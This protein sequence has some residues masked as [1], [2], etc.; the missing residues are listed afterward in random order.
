DSGLILRVKNGV[1]VVSSIAYHDVGPAEGPTPAPEPTATPTPSST[2]TATATETSAAAAP[3]D[4]AEAS[5]TGTPEAPTVTETP[6][7]VTPTG[8]PTSE[9]PTE[10]PTPEAPTEVPTETP[11]PEMPT[12]TPTEVP[13][14]PTATETPVVVTVTSVPPCEVDSFAIE[15]QTGVAPFTGKQ[16]RLIWRVRNAASIAIRWKDDG[17]DRAYRSTNLAD[18]T[19][20]GVDRRDPGDLTFQL[21]AY[22]DQAGTEP[23][24]VGPMA[25]VLSI[26][27]GAPPTTPIPQ[28]VINDLSI[29]P[30]TGV[31]PFNGN[32]TVRWNASGVA[33]I[34]IRWADDKGGRFVSTSSTG[35]T[36]IGVSKRAAGPIPFEITGYRDPTASGQSCV[37][38]STDLTVTAP[39]PPTATTRP[40][41]ILTPIIIPPK[42]PP[43]R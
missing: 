8:T 6:I 37:S 40:I 39:Q 27:P 1:V 41:I 33:S 31:A 18:E 21:F 5:P 24:C 35:S 22:R 15:P 4:A 14:Q 20:Q 36:Q 2:P 12:E 23:A 19:A 42:L 9:P 13:A 29:S 25:K 17:G 34:A 32:V 10:T 26:A 30:T 16:V 38:R 3:T 28:C 11:T 7:S 43:I